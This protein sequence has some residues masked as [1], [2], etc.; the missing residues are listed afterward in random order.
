LRVPSGG[1]SRDLDPPFS[2]RG[3]RRA[4]KDADNLTKGEWVRQGLR[5]RGGEDA[6][7]FQLKEQL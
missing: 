5:R 6:L 2:F 7:E 4:K 1:T 3:K